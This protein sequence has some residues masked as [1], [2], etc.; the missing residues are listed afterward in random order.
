MLA[1]ITFPEKAVFT[2]DIGVGGGRKINMRDGSLVI[3][4]T[5]PILY[6]ANWS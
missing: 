3:D 6:Q 2:R 4:W 1:F 5:I